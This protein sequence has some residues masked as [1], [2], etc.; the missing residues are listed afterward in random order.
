[1]ITVNMDKAKQVH[2][3]RMRSVREAAFKHVDADRAIA[4]DKGD[5]AALVSVKARAIELRDI[6]KHPDLLAAKTPDEL[7][8]VWPVC[9]GAR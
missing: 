3:N 2:L 6:T 5:Q 4:A 7:K 1:M 9:L 8:A